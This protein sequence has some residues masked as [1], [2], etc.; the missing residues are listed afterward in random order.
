MNTIV[1]MNH[2]PK[3][4]HNIALLEQRLTRREE[5][6]IELRVAQLV[7]QQAEDFPGLF[8]PDFIEAKKELIA[9]ILAELALY[10]DQEI[11]K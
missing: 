1:S 6:Q 4:P 2:S 10:E 9:E 5:L 8:S 7:I 3:H 11:T